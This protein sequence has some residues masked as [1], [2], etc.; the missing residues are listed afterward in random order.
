ME[1]SLRLTQQLGVLGCLALSLAGSAL[2]DPPAAPPARCALRLVVELSPD[3]PNP[4]DRSFVSSLLGDNPG[5]RLSLQHVIDDT[6][7]G[8]TLYGP[9]PKRNCRNVLES[10]RRDSRVQSIQTQ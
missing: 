3:V 10:M 1:R 8:M 6:H 2:A 7:L 5:Y 4:R 9:G